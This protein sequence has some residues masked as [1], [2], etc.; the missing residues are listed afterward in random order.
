MKLTES[1][2]REIIKEELS[3]LNERRKDWSDPSPDAVAEEFMYVYK[4]QEEFEDEY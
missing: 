4:S 3:S 1:R 2:L